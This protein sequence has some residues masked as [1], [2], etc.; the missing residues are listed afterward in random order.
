MADSDGPDVA[1]WVYQA[2]FRRGELDLD[3]IAYALDEA[4]TELRS[5]GASASRWAPFIHLGG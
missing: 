3:D 2:L 5:K 4:V 1:H